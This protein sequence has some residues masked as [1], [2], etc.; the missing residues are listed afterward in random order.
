MKELTEFTDFFEFLWYNG[1]K[2]KVEEER[3]CIK[4][5]KNKGSIMRSGTQLK[6]EQ[7]FHIFLYKI[8][9]FLALPY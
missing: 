5:M 7:V 6:L 1:T 3:R 4:A 8:L 9:L 2:A